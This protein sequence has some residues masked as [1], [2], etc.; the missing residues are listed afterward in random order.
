[1][2]EALESYCAA[3]AAERISERQLDE[4]SGILKKSATLVDK[5]RS[6]GKAVADKGVAKKFHS[7]DLAFHMTIIEASRNR[8]MLKVVGDSHILSR[9]FQADRHE[10]NLDILETTQKEHESIARAIAAQETT[11]SHDAMKKHI[12]NSLDLTLSETDNDISDRWWTE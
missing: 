7:L 2:R 11:A 3:R 9:I 4:L 6:S 1:M 5:V 12:R 10:F 8:R